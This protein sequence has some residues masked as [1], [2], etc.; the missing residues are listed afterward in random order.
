MEGIKQRDVYYPSHATVVT[1]KAASHTRCISQCCQYHHGVRT[2]YKELMRAS[3]GVV[4]HR[5]GVGGGVSGGVGRWGDVRAI[6]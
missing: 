4:M 3:V 5:S 6:G 2:Y 1:A